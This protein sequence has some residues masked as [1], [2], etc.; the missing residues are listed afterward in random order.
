MLREVPDGSRW[1]PDGLLQA[2]GVSA[3][4]DV[5]VPVDLRY[6]TYRKAILYI[7]RYTLFSEGHLHTE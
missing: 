1:W 4:V 5:W 3:D 2:D 6:L 7:H